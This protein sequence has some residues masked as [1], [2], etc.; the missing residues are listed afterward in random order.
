M[1]L[2]ARGS[3]L[4]FPL[5]LLF[6]LVLGAAF[7]A[8][9][10]SDFC[11]G[12]PLVNGS[13]VIDGNDPALTPLTLPSSIGIDANC[14]FQNFP[15]SPAKWPDGLT[16]TLNFKSDGFLAIFNNVYY[17][18]NMACAVTTTKI[19]FVNPG[20]I[21]A[22]N[23]SCQGLFIPVEAIAKQSPAATASVG[24]PFTYTLTIPVMFDPT[25]G[26]W[27]NNPSP[28]TLGNI[29]VSDNLTAAATG[30][31]M[32]LV[33]IN[34]YFKGSGVPV[35]VTNNGDS[36]HLD[37]TL[38]DVAAGSQ[39]VVEMTVVL[40]NTPT[41]TAGTQFINTAVWEFSRLIDGVL[42]SP[43][44]GQ[45]GVSTPMTI[46]EPSL[47]LTKMSQ[48]P[49][50]NLG[51]PANFTL[52]VQNINIGGGDAWDT[53]ILDNLPAGMCQYDPRSTV[54]AQIYESDGT[55]WVRD[56]VNGTD[57][58]LTWNGGTC[59]LSVTTLDTPAAK[60]G[61]TQRLIIKYQA[62]ID[63]TGVASG[64]QLTNVAGATRWFSGDISKT[65]RRQYG[66]Y[67]LTNGTP[68]TLDFQD[69]YTITAALA[70]Y[71]FQKTVQDLTTGVST[72]SATTPLTAF[73]G[74]R[75]R[76]TL[77]IQNFTWP[78]LSNTTMNDDL[79]AQNMSAVFQPNSLTLA[80]TDLPAGTYTVC[81]SCG[82]NGAGTISINGLTLGSNQQ[83]RI[84]FDVTLAS[85][86]TNGT[87]VLNQP[88]LTGVDTTSKVWSGV[89]DDPYINGTVL[90]GSG[91]DKTSLVI[92]AP[93]A[94]SK[95]SPASGTAPIG[96]PFSYLITVP[97]V[98][99]NVPM[100]DVHILDNLPANVNFVSAQVVSGGTWNLTN[101]G[102]T[103]NLVLQDLATGIDIPAG[104]Q[105]VIGVTVAVQ[106]IAA[107]TN[108]VSFVNNASYTYNKIQGGGISTQ[109]T[110]A[111]GSASMSVVEPH[112]IAAKTVSYASPAG[113]AITVPAKVGDVL[114][115]TITIPNNGSS[116]AYDADVIDT[117]PSNVQL[118]NVLPA[119]INGGPVVGF[120]ASPATSATAPALPP[121]TVA[122]GSTYNSDGSLDI[123]VGETLVLTYQVQVM[124]VNGAP[125]TNT[126]WAA[127]NSLDG[128]ISGERTGAGCPTNIVSPNNY[129]T[130]PASATPVP[131]L[132][133]TTI[134]KSVVSDSWITA[135]ST[136]IDKILRIGDTVVYQLA[137]SLRAGALQIVAV[138]DQLPAGLVFDSVVSINGDTSA[139]FGQTAPFTYA[140][141]NA[142]SVSGSTVIW[143]F[144]NITNSSSANST[145][146]IQYRA[147]V[148]TNTLTQQPAT[149]LNNTATLSYTGSAL[150]NSSAAIT[151]WQ[152]I[153]STPTKI[154][155]AGRA[156][157]ALVNVTADTMQFRLG[158][159]NNGTAPAYSVKFIDLLASQLNQTTIT[160]PGVSVGGTLLTAGTDY[161]YTPPA[162]R[163][164]TMI[165]VLNTPVNPGQCVTID[166]N[167]GFY[168]DFGPN[169]TWNNSVTLDEYWSLPLQSGQKYGALGPA[170]FTMTNSATISQPSKTLS[171][172]A[173]GEATIGDA[174][175]YLITV[176]TTLI[177]AA[178][179]DVTV[180][181][182]LD[183]SLV[184]LSATEVSGNNFTL[185]DSSVAPGQVNLTLAQIPAGKQAIIEVHARV[186]NNSTANAGVSFLNSASYTYADT[187]GGARKSGGIGTTA[188]PLQIIEPVVT[189][190]K[191]VSNQTNPGVPPTVGD[192]LRYMLVFQ[193]A[194]GPGSNSYSS[195]FDLSIAEALSLGIAYNG[196]VTV[197]GA[198]NTVSAPIITGDGITVPQSL[199]WGPAGSNIDIP[200]GTTVT[201]SYEVKVLI[202][203]QS[204][205]T[206]VASTRAQW[207]G[208][209]GANNDERTGSGTPAVNDY[210]LGP[211]A[212][213][214]ITKLP[215]LTFTKTVTAYDA[216]TRQP[217]ANAKPGDTLK[218]TL[219][220]Q[221]GGTV[222]ATNFTLTDELD[223]LN[224]PALFVPGSL[225]LV[226][227]P[228]GAN[229]TLTSAT[230]GAKG[231]GLVSISSLNIDPQ[232]GANDKL[233]IEFQAKL[234][235]V[236]TSGTAVLN[237]A[238]IGSSTLPTMASDDPS[239][240]GT[241]DPTRTLITSAPAFRVLKTAQDITSNTSIVMA[242]DTLR[243]TITVKN[244]G[245]ENAVG[246]TL[247][248][249]IP[250]NTS[251][252]ASSTRLNGGVVAD[253][254]AGVSVLQNG[255]SINSPANLTTGAMPADAGATATNVSTITF[256]V[257]ISTNVVNG[258]IISNQGFVNGSGAGSGTFPEQP[259]D[260]P[261]TPVLSD[262]TSVVVGNLPLLYA[263]K[264]VQLV[265]DSNNNGLV[266]PGDV[267]QYT[268]TLNNSGATP[269]TGVV[270]TDA[271]PAN[272][273]YVANS[274][275]MNSA[276]VAD[277][278][279]G[280]SPLTSGIGVVSSGQTPPSPLS[281]GGT[282]ATGGTGIVTF[283]VQVNAGVP[284][285]TIISNQGS[286][287]TTQLP[288]LLTDS[289]G[290]PANGYQPTVIVVGNAQQLTI[291]KQVAVVGGGTADVGAEL[292]YLVRVTNIGTVAATSVV[293]TDVL[294]GQL[295]FVPGSAVLNGSSAGINV[296][297]TVIIADYS[298][299]SGSLPANGTAVLRFHA[300][301]LSGSI[302]TK[303]TNTAQVT[304]NTPSQNASGSASVD[305]GGTPGSVML[306]GHTWHDANFNKACDSSERELTG[307]TVQ[308][309]RNSQ[310]LGSMPTDTSGAYRFSGLAP[311][312]TTAAADQY[313]VRFSAPGATANTA[314]LGLADSAFTNGLQRISGITA[315]SG[316][317]L[318]N[319][320]L[321]ID[322]SG[323]VYD[324]VRRTPI[325]GATVTMAR[326]STNS[327]LPAS[328][329]ADPAQQ[330]QVTLAPGYYKFD[331]NFSDPSCPTGADYVIR[332]TPPANGYRP[333]PSGIIAP[334]D[335]TPPFSV[336]GCPGTA[337]DAIPATTSFCEAQPSEFAPATSVPAGSA[338]TRYYLHF[339]LSN[340]AAGGI[341]LFN[342]H[343]PVDPPLNTAVSITKTALLTNVSRGQMV[344]Y[345]IT[346]KNTLGATLSNL[347]V[348]DRF[349]PGFKYVAGSARFDGNPLEPVKTT[350]ELRW[351][352]LQLADGN[353]IIKLLLVVGA[354]VKEGN[355]DNN[356]QVLSSATGEAMTTVATARVRIV[357]D[358]TF[359]CTDI[360]GKVFDDANAN[361]YPDP[362]EK[363][364]GGVRIVS[365]RG[366]IATTDKYGRF[367]ITCAAVPDEDRGSNFILKL[368]D[369]TLPTGYR[370]TSEN[371]LVLR[372][373]RGKA[374]KF[375]FGATLHRVVRLDIADGVFEPG[376][377][378]IRP[379][380]KPKIE[381]LL[382]ELRKAPAILRISYLADVEDQA[383]VKARTQA[384]KREIADRWE[385]GS[386]ELTIETEI[387]WR[388][389]GPPTSRPVANDGQ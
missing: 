237:Q 263:Q 278:S 293:I 65:G 151:I 358:P 289:D 211:I 182:T 78:T 385:Q 333:T 30:A 11:S 206:L 220:I 87:T 266:D 39:I 201:V 44:P 131:T 310:L 209:N 60:I 200:E 100:Y 380:W 365:A 375:N 64:A 346:V 261:A 167:I 389:G 274:T 46:G 184:Y 243:Y 90:L 18:G 341:E 207:T 1:A 74:D 282:L 223:K 158:S 205:Q 79:G 256:D 355:Y 235:P 76:Y 188:I 339:L 267:L 156:S 165:F 294:P 281:N 366:L 21:Y 364:L 275:A 279:A 159:C 326:A 63:S 317:N 6:A 146:V 136:G 103:T 231:T 70:G 84:Q 42:H 69:T 22:P 304:W 298:S 192:V 162:V 384:V 272:T 118:Y 319:L 372:L 31:E 181:D 268:I 285:G 342:N 288:T 40:D 269:A 154:D 318:Q 113:Q 178:L 233:V 83:Y 12:Y 307:W 280:V 72:Y 343:I 109:G 359:D 190:I 213:S 360:I 203:V 51:M 388:R 337:D 287:A 324:S 99:A 312:T 376:S 28:N 5:L 133:P 105:A 116:E 357:P 10:G 129:C 43:L 300:R 259:S 24:V 66:P 170:I 147:R 277:P 353:H 191:S 16:S 155:R 354:G 15:Q 361:G 362:D 3:R 125:L 33:G 276:V 198:G 296:A 252:V 56:L 314:L 93:G 174:V 117:L 290:N 241:S 195:A 161:T 67:P 23:N 265:V 176:P 73:P 132:D 309:Y 302:G 250:A 232:G 49:T 323:V 58:Q 91:G 98:A 80:G 34:A 124:S 347:S 327:A 153:M 9:A 352:N 291:N 284:S 264:T 102:T 305:I 377:A 86:L 114:Q 356:A 325:A 239:L 227:V 367:H 246:V 301:I 82:T 97:A 363:G 286:V 88:S 144:G 350:S 48:T 119:Q 149:G 234:V 111:A 340:S 374:I 248:D 29:R 148:A 228:A 224:S 260:N 254:V 179:Y 173:S 244:I 383:V 19:W 271:V 273:T 351:E 186:A 334:T 164:G 150:L 107:N 8:Q 37:F 140:D 14:T 199:S 52:N 258:T 126:A 370:V 112:L 229:T 13:H 214:I 75:V 230:G 110:G 208:L 225:T 238:Q 95:T 139:P 180:A 77:L 382:G 61:P 212:A 297:G 27:Y 345:V 373:T 321:P 92:N 96:Q 85:T 62:E 295:S 386:Y 35:P 322:P 137:L 135:P 316:S 106:N 101:T 171:A 308:V 311:T 175:V 157:P 50:I 240:P 26:T 369:R 54:T 245:T 134:T 17:S 94:L 329:F 336:P 7:S 57:F 348:V 68:G 270:L 127:W 236:I 303:L 313:E 47:T 41:N 210:F 253:P 169:Q 262:P 306:N 185:A 123:R 45:S 221:N 379:Q 332:V 160:P 387:Y 128:G 152:P 216:I 172:P 315:V 36:K 81:S 168:T 249:Q 226:T 121:G 217:V 194:G 32:T 59:Q 143:N 328:C 166:Y 338:G 196:N 218:Y 349:P 283:K 104:G 187:A 292:E 257:R 202:N 120:K 247:R 122:W 20:A 89:S 255:M 378:E 330:N 320:N 197:T 115:Y 138:A 193:A 38:P 251:Y 219:T 189:L 344:P 177:N 215:V 183:S 25:T 71:Y 381:M 4:G 142:P 371:P 163:G 368:D 299:V 130:A 335:P 108:G 204:G 141:F 222:G 242:G 55:T 53:T 2:T 145:F 331:L